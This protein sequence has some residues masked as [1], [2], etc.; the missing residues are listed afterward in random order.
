LKLVWRLILNTSISVRSYSATAVTFWYRYNWERGPRLSGWEREM[1]SK[2]RLSGYIACGLY[3]IAAL[4]N[5][6]AEAA[7]VNS[8]FISIKRRHQ[9]PSRFTTGL[10]GRRN[11]RGKGNPGIY[12]TREPF[13]ISFLKLPHRIGNIVLLLTS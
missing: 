5:P 4:L 13:F 8:K 10:R 7:R 6:I 11:G 1:I 9:L 3:F 12:C 2:P